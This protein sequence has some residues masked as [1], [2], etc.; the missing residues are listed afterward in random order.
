MIVSEPDADTSTFDDFVRVRG[1]A[2]WRAAYLLTGNPDSAED[3]VQTALSRTFRRYDSMANDSVFEAFV[4]TTM[5]RTFCSWWRRAWRGE[6][7]TASL[8]DAEEQQPRAEI[9]LDVLRALRDL[10]PRQRSILVLRFFEDKPV[11]EVATI[12][13]ITEGTVKSASHKGCASLRGSVHLIDQE[14]HH[15]R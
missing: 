14:A 11:S 10:P 6:V 3:L 2:L 1:R 5:Y 8:P 9:S 13:G 15:E 4:R 7:P 12:L